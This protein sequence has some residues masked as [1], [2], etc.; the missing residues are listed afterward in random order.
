MRREIVMVYLIVGGLMMMTGVG[1]METDMGA[2]FPWGHFCLA[3]FGAGVALHGAIKL[4][5]EQ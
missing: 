5:M 4:N 3:F 1:G 2:T